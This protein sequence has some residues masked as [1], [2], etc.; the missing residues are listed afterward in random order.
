MTLVKGGKAD[1]IQ[2]HQDRYK[3]YC[4]GILELGER[5]GSTPNVA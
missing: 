2:E 5:L 1:F 4:N 3:D